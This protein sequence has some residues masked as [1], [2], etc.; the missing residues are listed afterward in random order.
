MVFISFI[1]DL[2]SRDKVT[3]KC[4]FC[5][6]EENIPRRIVATLDFFDKGDPAFPPSFAC[7]ECMGAMVPL[8]YTNYKGVVYKYKK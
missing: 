1:K 7:R 3:F 8:N 4:K 2:F 6:V 5:K